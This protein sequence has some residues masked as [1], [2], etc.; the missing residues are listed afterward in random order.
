MPLAGSVA[1]QADSRWQTVKYTPGTEH[2]SAVEPPDS[3]RKSA[4]ANP[5]SLASDK[6]GDLGEE[7][8]VLSQKR[9]RDC[10]CNLKCCICVF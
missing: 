7:I 9:K 4:Q 2:L 5:Q 8:L 1:S 6:D 10:T 3:P